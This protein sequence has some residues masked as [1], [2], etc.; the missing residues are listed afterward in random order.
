MIPCMFGAIDK[1]I[2]FEAHDSG[3]TQEAMYAN[4]ELSLG[5]FRD[6]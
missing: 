2:Q 5:R 4:Y 1:F 3:I 6:I